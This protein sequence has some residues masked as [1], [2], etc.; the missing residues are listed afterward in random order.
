MSAID[1]PDAVK[2][3]FTESLTA[4]DVAEPLASCDAEVSAV[5]VREFMDARDFDVVGIRREGQVVGYVE[6]SSLESGDCGQHLRL[7]DTVSVISGMTPLLVVLTELDRSPFLFITV[8]GGV[9][10]I[11]TRADL[12]KPPAQRLVVR[13]PAPS[14]P[15]APTPSCLRC[16]E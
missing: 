12:H 9:G 6:R 15:S 3:V 2:R 13:R 1:I 8:I 11:V 7:F 14:A 4:R 5:A 10:G 16:M